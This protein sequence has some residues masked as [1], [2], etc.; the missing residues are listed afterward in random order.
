MVRKK[1][2]YSYVRFSRPEQ[3]KGDSLRRQKEASQKWCEKNGY[4]L[5]DSLR[6]EDH[7]RS[8][9]RGDNVLK[10]KLGA[11]IDAVDEGRVKK[12]SVLIVESLDRLSRQAVGIALSMFLDLLSKGISIVTLEPEE[13]FN[14]DSM[15]ETVKLI[16]VIV[17]LSRAYEESAMKSH[18][19]QKAWEE[20]RRKAWD[21]GK[22]LTART[23]TW[24]IKNGDEFEFHPEKSL[25]VKRI[26]KLYLD[27]VGAVA[28]A[29]KFNRENIPTLGIGKQ[30][31]QMWRKSTILKILR[32][33]ALIGEYQPHLGKSNQDQS[34]RQKIGEPIVDYYPELISEADFYR[35]QKRLNERKIAGRTG[36]GAGSIS[37]LFTGLLFDARD[38]SSMHMVDKGS[39]AAG[40]QIVSS[41]A[42]NGKGEYISFQY[43]YFE[44]AILNLMKTITTQDILPT[45]N[46]VDIQ[47]KLEK[48]IG[49]LGRTDNKIKKI[50][51]QMESEDDD[52]IDSLLPVLSKLSKRK[53]ELEQEIETLEAEIHSSLPTPDET[54]KLV[55]LLQGDPSDEIDTHRRRFRTVLR[56]I[57]K[58]IDVLTLK[59]GHWRQCF[60]RIIFQNGRTRIVLINVHRKRLVSSGGYDGDYP[61][62]D[63]ET[64]QYLEHRLSELKVRSVKET[65]KNLE[66]QIIDAAVGKAGYIEITDDSIS[67]EESRK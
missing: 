43:N 51:V 40:K 59:Q 25:I 27:G 46:D 29:S 34:Q 39:R 11:F 28:I 8:A 30:A 7:G 26:I 58:R 9:F 18:R 48:K 1:V 67:Y 53:R 19:L 63:E 61:I 57:V 12:G 64:Q 21:E 52:L 16:V 42:R 4:I 14:K 22:K 3:L 10:G 15:N 35:V 31:A 45:R 41:A 23:P 47:N 62:T 65:E 56:N 13:F 33:R 24:I 54:Q 66:Q 60:T 20:K 50:Q 55:E 2:A 36:N 6:L 5:D 44:T 17:I 49:Q 38:G 32:N 37:N